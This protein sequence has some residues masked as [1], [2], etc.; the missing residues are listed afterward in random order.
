MVKLMEKRDVGR[1]NIGLE[2]TEPWSKDVLEFLPL[3]DSPSLK[4]LKT[5]TAQND[6][7]A[8]YC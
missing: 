2:N 8:A 6:L 3:T 4:Q 7:R 5:V 1:G